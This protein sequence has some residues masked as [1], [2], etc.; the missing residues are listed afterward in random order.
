MG[1]RPEARGCGTGTEGESVVGLIEDMLGSFS[2]TDEALHPHLTQALTGLMGNEEDAG[3]GL[4]GLLEGLQ[5]SG[6]GGL[7]GSWLGGGTN[8]P[9]T[10][11]QIRDALGDQEVE[12]SAR[13]AGMPA[14]SLLET[15]AEHLPGLIDRLSPQGQLL[16]AWAGPTS[17]E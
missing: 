5:T 3:P 11:D 6:L 1:T 8:L 7:V 13:R 4:H 9:V 17:R 15:L 12:A 14:A 16:P 2:G 10:P